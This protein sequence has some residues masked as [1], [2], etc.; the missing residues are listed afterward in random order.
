MRHHWALA[1]SVLAVAGEAGNVCA[2]EITPRP[3]PTTPACAQPNVPART[4]RAV[5]PDTPA[6]AAQQ[7]IHGVV[8]VVVSIDADSHV[9]GARIMSSPSAVLNQAAITAARQST[10]QAQIRGCQP[11]AA[12]YIFSV[13]FARS[14]TFAVAA[15]GER[16]VSVI[17]RGSALRAPDSAVI[18]ASII[19]RDLVAANASAKNDALFEALKTKLGALQV[20]TGTIASLVSVQ[21]RRPAA[22]VTGYAATRQVRITADSVA[23][24]TDVA[25]AVASQPGVEAVAIRYIVRDHA[26]ASRDALTN[27]LNDAEQAA[28]EAV[29][30]KNLHLGA[31]KDIAVQPDGLA[32]A[33]YHIVPYFLV[34]VAGGF[35]EPDIRIPNVVVYATATVIYAVNP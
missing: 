33:P 23:N 35:K 18:Q 22:E 5:E 24:A 17:G 16:T 10:F 34:P 13:D 28:R 15:S 27:A 20:K 3:T 9:V 7:G 12:D 6:L 31:R 19:T 25:A 29:A 8:Q 2:Q 4:I 30:S 21:P 1:A 32:E 11:I 14:V 26:A